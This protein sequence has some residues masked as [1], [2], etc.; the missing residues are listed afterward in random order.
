[1][2][3]LEKPIFPQ[4]VGLKFD[5]CETVGELIEVLKQLPPELRVNPSDD[6]VKPVIFNV[7]HH[8]VQLGLEENDGTWDDDPEGDDDE[9][10]A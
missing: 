7:M 10:A 6:G 3:R 1:M 8:D 4:L 5:P 9:D 2:A